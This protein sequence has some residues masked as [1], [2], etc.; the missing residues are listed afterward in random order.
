MHGNRLA[1]Q[2]SLRQ[3]RDT[4]EDLQM[5][6]SDYS[7]DWGSVSLTL[8]ALMARF[9]TLC[10]SVPE[11]S[12]LDDVASMDVGGRLSLPFIRRAT[13]LLCVLYRH[14]HLASVA[15][16]VPH[17][18][19]ETCVENCHV[20]AAMDSFFKHTMH[21]DLPAAARIVYKQEFTGMYNSVTQVVYFHFPSYER[22]RQPDIPAARQGLSL[23]QCLSVALELN[24][25]VPVAYEDDVVGPV[26][27]WMLVA[28]G[29]VYLIS[30]EKEVY[31]G[32]CIWTL[33]DVIT[34]GGE[35]FI[36]DQTEG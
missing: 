2:L 7:A 3:L 35:Q 9:G 13:A 28:G 23:P 11:Q 21:A 10:L 25:D 16:D 18:R 1:S 26:W 24:P 36:E 30:P 12:A 33:A 22:Q 15:V 17:C 14:V 20:Q 34:H 6:L 27:T 8:D 31:T 32:R 29:A 4:L 5:H 19:E